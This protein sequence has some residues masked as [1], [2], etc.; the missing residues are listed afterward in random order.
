[1]KKKFTTSDLTAISLMVVLISV[2]AFI[3]I[4]FVPVPLTLQFF[5]INLGMLVLDKNKTAIAVLVYIVAGLCGL[6]IFTSGG[7]IQYVLHPTFGYII[8][9]LV[10]SFFGGK[11]KDALLRKLSDRDDKAS[12]FKVFLASSVMNMAIVYIIGLPFMIGVIKLYLSL[13]VGIDKLIMSGFVL[14][15]P[16]DIVKIVISSLSAIKLDNKI[17]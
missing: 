15:L 10:G 4:P 7:G 13:P 3:K 16:G 14:T 2:G 8:G 5:F 17:S 6:P 9:M 11:L 12:L 1:M